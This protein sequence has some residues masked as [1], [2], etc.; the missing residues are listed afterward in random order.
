[1]VPFSNFETESRLT[2][3]NSLVP[4]S[5]SGNDPSLG[6]TFSVWPAVLDCGMEWWSYVQSL[7]QKEALEASDVTQLL[8]FLQ[9][10][11]APLLSLRNTTAVSA[12]SLRQTNGPR[13]ADHSKREST[14][15][16]QFSVSE[17]L[18]Y[19]KDG[20]KT[21]SGSTSYNLGSLEDF[22]PMESAAST[23]PSYRFGSCL[24]V[25]YTRIG[26][27]GTRLHL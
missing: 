12:I 22:P 19:H 9:E 18:S 26:L 25:A 2:V 23:S 16:N 14:S 7:E 4:R 21:V 27:I 8:Q 13:E 1:M 6:T 3:S 11:T 17:P 24:S 5:R 20:R 15:Q 10:H